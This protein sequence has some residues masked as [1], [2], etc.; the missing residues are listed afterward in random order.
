MIL[1]SKD[2]LGLIETRGLVAAIE[3]LDASL[4]AANVEFASY[5]FT[6]GGLVCIIVTGE[7]GAVRAAVDAGSAAATRVGELITTHVIPRPADDTMTIIDE[8]SGKKPVSKKKPDT[9]EPDENVINIENEAPNESTPYTEE[10]LKEAVE[11]LRKFLQNTE[12]ESI[13][14]ED[15]RLDEYGVRTLRKVMKALPFAE[16]IKSQIYTMR[17]Q[18]IIETLMEFA[19]KEGKDELDDEY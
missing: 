10:E 6:T 19:K 16:T 1:M 9:A 8:I 18:E 14:P 4:K 7:V 13:L 2:A 5:R 3:A 15:K 17:K 12:G 11:I